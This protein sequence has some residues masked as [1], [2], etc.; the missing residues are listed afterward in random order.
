MLG[1]V[2]VYTAASVPHKVPELAQP[3]ESGMCSVFA[4]INGGVAGPINQTILCV[5][6]SFALYLWFDVEEPVFAC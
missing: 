4:A 5:W 6:V 1:M 3:N 2:C